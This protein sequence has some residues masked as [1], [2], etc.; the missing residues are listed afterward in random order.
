MREYEPSRGTTGESLR[1][2]SIVVIAL[3][4]VVTVAHSAAHMSL[5][6][7]MNGWQ[8]AYIFV[9]IVLLPLVA[10]YVIWKRARGGYLILVLSMLGALLFGGYYHFVLAGADNVSTVAHHA[11]RSWAQLFHAS[12]VLLVVVEAAGVVVAAIGLRGSGRRTA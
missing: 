4:A 8:N 10:A 7:L 2:L 5:N 11:S 3:H 1:R 12:A 9:V 6:I